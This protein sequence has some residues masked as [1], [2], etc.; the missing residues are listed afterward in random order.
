MFAKLLK[1]NL[2][3]SLPFFLLVDLIA[4]AGAILHRVFSLG[5]SAFM[6]FAAEFCSGI[7]FAMVVNALINTIIRG[8]A[9]FRRSFYGDESYLTHTLPIEPHTIFLAKV[10]ETFIILVFNLI[11]AAVA[12]LIT[13]GK[14][15]LVDFANSV[16]SVFATSVNMPIW[17]LLSIL[18][19]IA[20][21]EAF[22]AIVIGFLGI[23]FG[24]KK[25]SN[26]ISWSLLF[27]FVVYIISQILLILIIL[28]AS[29]FKTEILSIFTSQG[30]TDSSIMRILV[31]LSFIA[32]LLIPTIVVLISAKSL[33][34]GVD[35]E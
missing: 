10:L 14:T 12:I 1:Y 35:V 20:F 3:K 5:D 26:K 24:H 25:D 21:L 6:A 18:I 23:I 33:D 22:S 11:V 29:L 16:F 34:R 15:N 17:L 28:A 7:M 8:W 4:I 9:M 2:K 32:Y 30:I 13:F 27:G 31:V 19:G